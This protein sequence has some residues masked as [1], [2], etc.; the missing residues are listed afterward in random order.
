MNNLRSRHDVWMQQWSF[1][2]LPVHL[3]E[4]SQATSLT[5]QWQIH[6][7]TRMSNVWNGSE[8]GGKLYQT[9]R[10]YGHLIETRCSCLRKQCLMFHQQLLGSESSANRH[11]R[12]ILGAALCPI[13]STATLWKTCFVSREVLT[14]KMITQ[15]MHSMDQRSIVFFWGKQL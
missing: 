15:H 12:T 4:I 3:F 6:V 5:R 10:T 13:A 7:L 14:G 8:P 2:K 9:V 11:S 1:W